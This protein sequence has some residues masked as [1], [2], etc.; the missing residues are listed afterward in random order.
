[1]TANGNDS[2]LNF[3]TFFNIIDGKLGSTKET[4][5]G[6]NPATNE[7][8]LPCPVSTLQDVDEAVNAAQVAFKSWSKTS[9]EHRKQQL[10]AFAAA[11]TENKS[12]FAKLLTSEQG[13]PVRIH[14]N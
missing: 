10:R 14:R 2:A 5:N 6:I 3:S 7:E 1:M 4:R 11:L 12:E 8:L 9:V 13:K